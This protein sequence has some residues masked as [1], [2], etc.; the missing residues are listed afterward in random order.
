M[1]QKRTGLWIGLVSVLVMVGIIVALITRIPSTAQQLPP[2]TAPIS[3]V[4]SHPAD[5]STWPADTP[6]PVAVMVSGGAPLKSVEL[7]TDGRLFDTKIPADD[8]KSSFK[9][10]S[11]MPLTEGTHAIFARATDVNGQTADSNAVHIRASAAAGLI[12]V[13]TALEGETIQS[14]AEQNGVTPEKIAAE[15]PSID[16]AGPIPPGTQ[17]FISFQPFNLPAGG[18]P[19]NSPPPDGPVIP[20]EEGEP[21]GPAFYLEDALNLNSDTPGAPSLFA[22]VGVCNV[23]LTIQDNSSDENGFFVYA[24]PDTSVSFKRISSLKAH[25]GASL[26]QYIIP[27][28]SGHVQYYVSSYNSAG[29]SP[30]AP[31]AVN[32]TSP[33]CNPTQGSQGD[34]KYEGG[35]LTVPPGV[36]LAYFYASMNGSAWQRLPAGDE[37]L[38]PMTGQL[39]LRAKIQQ[40]LGGAPSGEVD[41]DVWGWR[42]GALEHLGII[43]IN[44]NFASLAICNLTGGCGGDMGA[45]H[46]VTEATVG[47]DKD[48]TTRPLRWTAYGSDITHAIWQVSTQPFPAEYSVGA[49]PGLLISGISEAVVNNETGLAGG[50]FSIDFNADLQVAGGEN[51]D[52][53]SARRMGMLDDIGSFDPGLL[54]LISGGGINQLGLMTYNLWLPQKLYIRVTPIAGN[55]PASDPSNTVLVSYQPTGDPPPIK[56]SKV[57]TYSVEIVPGS[58]VN[59]VKVVQ[60]LGTLGCSEITGVDKDVFTSWFDQTYEGSHIDPLDPYNSK[61]PPLTLVEEAYNFW[62]THIGYIA[63]PGI[64][65]EDEPN[66]FEQFAAALETS[67][68]YLSST[69]EQLK[70]I[71]VGALAEII[72]GCGQGCKSVLM[73]GLNFAITYFTGLPP[74]IPNF[75]DAVNMGIDYAVQ[76]A[77]SQ[78]G[79]PYCDKSC[80]DAIAD[81]IKEV[82]ADVVGS[83]KSQPACNDQNHTLWLYEGTQQLHLKPLCFPPGVSFDPLP[84][85]M[86]ERAMVQVK[87]TRIDGSP[88]PVPMQVL[89]LNTQALNPAFGDGHSVT[90]YY[91]ATVQENCQIYQGQNMCASVTHTFPY[92]MVYSAPLFG[93][94]YPQVS[95][96]IPALK[97]GQSVVVPVVFKSQA[98]DNKPPNVYIPRAAAI[99]N[100]Y[101]EADLNTI[102]V[103]WWRDFS[104]LT[105]SSAQIT[106]D[107]RV[108]CQDKELQ[109]LWNSPCS[110]IDTQ[111]F[112]VP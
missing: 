37:F 108:I 17:V 10:W 13:H 89:T 58:Y 97:A 14:L 23:T 86:Y 15:N 51:G 76:M 46:W 50:D 96:S 71:L 82:G 8:Q 104:H 47:S 3:I 109:I 62:F 88:E 16:P 79:I 105:D 40:L 31:V 5:G 103:D 48:Q 73:T 59:E 34:L 20:A 67:W 35:F 75:D 43:H 32:V 99:Q 81:E 111:E 55:H 70:G 33:Q 91:Q 77:I 80:K 69:L 44:A 21:V 4:L 49:P 112:I 19:P 98:Y 65:E 1:H 78:A 101:P 53:Q 83:G 9:V 11:W 106:I 54:P 36:D 95:V 29:E 6:I 18:E 100:T 28:Q 66:L 84:G 45:T 7:W 2:N 93:V 72:P 107:A 102:P 63:C 12:A 94:P 26:L 27:D 68:N 56:I 42:D 38:E 57:P 90:E 110:E 85:S 87:V 64:V 52:G 39:D 22:S 61:D 30:S 25:S 92:D 60:K 74:S 24:L 41:L